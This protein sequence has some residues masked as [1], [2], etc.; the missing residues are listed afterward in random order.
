MGGTE[1]NQRTDAE[2]EWDCGGGS[3]QDA[4]AVSGAIL[5]GIVWLPSVYGH[6]ASKNLPPIG[7]HRD[8]EYNRPGGYAASAPERL[9]KHSVLSNLWD[10]KRA[11]LILLHL[12]RTAIPFEAQTRDNV[13]LLIRDLLKGCGPSPWL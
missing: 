9:G 8:V 12:V 5:P 4:E 2:W 11:R 13:P 10:C 1:A 7:L 3:G 6:R